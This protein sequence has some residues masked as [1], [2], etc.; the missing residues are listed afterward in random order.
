M[1]VRVAHG[2][3]HSNVETMSRGQVMSDDQYVAAFCVT[4]HQLDAGLYLKDLTDS[5]LLA[6]VAHKVYYKVFTTGE[7]L[8]SP[9]RR[10]IREALRAHPTG[11]DL[12]NSIGLR[13]ILR[14]RPVL[15]ERWLRRSLEIDPDNMPSFNNL[16]QSLVSQE[17]Y[18]EAIT[19]AEEFDKRFPLQGNPLLLRNLGRAY[20]R[21][22]S[23]D[24]AEWVYHS[25]ESI[26]AATRW[27]VEKQLILPYLSCL[28]YLRGEYDKSASK[29]MEW[30]RLGPENAIGA[31]WAASAHWSAGN[32]AEARRVVSDSAA[33][34]PYISGLGSLVS[35]LSS[36]ETLLASFPDRAA[37][38]HS[39]LGELWAPIDLQRAMGHW[40]TAVDTGKKHTFSYLR[41]V[42][43]VADNCLV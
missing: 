40:K 33:T 30:T 4:P 1:F 6:E 27:P 28:Y 2:A 41:A 39:Y 34:D 23:Y 15:A 26:F 43:N 37:E 20:I 35:G 31:V 36:G 10:V 29:S 25:L 42:R 14:G 7:K 21:V 38:T 11:T 19:A 12:M 16:V 3:G 22:G 9:A 18:A 32:T 5:Q 17:K 13:Y 24:S 8:S